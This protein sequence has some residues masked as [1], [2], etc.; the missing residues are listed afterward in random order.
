M[1]NCIVCVLESVSG[2]LPS[3]FSGTKQKAFLTQSSLACFTSQEGEA[4]TSD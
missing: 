1:G 2:L 3:G 4:N